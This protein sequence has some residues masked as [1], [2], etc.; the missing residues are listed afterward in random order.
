MGRLDRIVVHI[1]VL[2]VPVVDYAEYLSDVHYRV[3][4]QKWLN[5]L[6]GDKDKLI[7]Q[8]MDNY[9]KNSQ[10]SAHKRLIPISAAHEDLTK[11]GL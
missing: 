4:F 10:A 9:Q 2:D 5:S 7:Q 8:I 11:S 1:E 6:W 3:N